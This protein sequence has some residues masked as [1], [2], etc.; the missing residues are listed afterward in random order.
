MGRGSKIVLSIE[1]KVKSVRIIKK[2]EFKKEFK[3]C[4]Y[5]SAHSANKEKP[6]K[7]K[8]R[9]TCTENYMGN[10]IQLNDLLVASSVSV[11]S[12]FSL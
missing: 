10:A 5:N 9:K 11:F 1:Y 4:V 6:K 8:L 12:V 7:K 3:F 2:I